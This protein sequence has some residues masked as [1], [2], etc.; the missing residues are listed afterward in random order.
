MIELACREVVFHF[1][2]HHLSDPTT[3]M[4][5]IKTKGKTYYVN[6]V[7]CNISWS[8]KETPSSSHTK[9]AIKIRKALLKINENNEAS[10]LPLSKEDEER[11][12]GSNEPRTRIL[13]HSRKGEIKDYVREQGIKHGRFQNITGPCGTSYVVV[14]IRSKQAMVLLS[15]V[16]SDAYRI[17]QE[18][19]NYHMIYDDLD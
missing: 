18:N 16:F 19:E 1:N 7:E 6:H 3:P 14:E 10:L 17:L 9:G 5:T 12:S 11:L 15:L 8:T 13:I 4:W 2:K